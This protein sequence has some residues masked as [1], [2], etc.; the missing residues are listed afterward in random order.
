MSRRR[1]I[2]VVAAATAVFL[3]FLTVIFVN[4]YK[5]DSPYINRKGKTISDRFLVPEGFVRVETEEDSFGYFLQNYPLKKY[6]YKAKHYNGKVNRSAPALGVFDQDITRKDLQ[7]C[8]DACMRLWAEYLYE[9]KEYDRISFTFVNGFVCDY[10]SWAEGKRV[11]VDDS[12]CYWYEG[13]EKDYSY[14]TF[15]KY[16][17]IV[18]NYANTTSLQQQ[19]DVVNPENIQIGDIFIMTAKQMGSRLGH[20][21]IVVDMC[22]NPVTGEKLLLIAESTTPASETY[23]VTSRSAEYG[24]WIKIGGTGNLETSGWTCPGEYIRRMK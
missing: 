13:A 15:R 8:A 16:M 14:G 21:V 1:I 2:T 22:V 5:K 12:I 3:M 9:Q 18:H 11:R 6:G 19:S 10:I 20:A 17:D 4:K 23:V 7:Q 24:P